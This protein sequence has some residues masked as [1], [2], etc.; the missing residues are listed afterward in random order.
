MLFI[1]ILFTT[2]CPI[3][4]LLLQTFRAFLDDSS[5]S[6]TKIVWVEGWG[7]QNIDDDNKNWIIP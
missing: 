5:Y 7:F 1:H 2:H 3:Q 6:I 4:C